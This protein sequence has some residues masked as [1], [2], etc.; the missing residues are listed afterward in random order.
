MK[1]KSLTTRTLSGIVYVALI[2]GCALWGLPGITLLAVLLGVL[3]VIEFNKITSQSTE[4]NTLVLITDICGV[5]AIAL[6]AWEFTIFVWLAIMLLR[7]TLEIYDTGKRPIQNVARSMMGQLYIGVPMAI[8]PII[9]M[10]QGSAMTVLAIFLLIW[11]NDT[12]AFL[13]GCTI[14]RHK[15]FE[16]V[17]PKKSWEGF[18]GG[19]AFTIAGSMSLSYFC[20]EIFM[21][22]HN[23]W[24]ALGLG[25]TVTLFATWGDLFESLIKRSLGIKDSGNIIPGHGGILDRVDSLLFVMPATMIYFHLV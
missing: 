7:M 17:S 13:V 22:Y 15:L 2:V 24:A 4:K 9:S 23:L 6:A 5:A 18:Y 3:A 20:P 19:L 8:M 1:I 14:G 10:Y 16:R 21:L 11:L 25:V 12:G